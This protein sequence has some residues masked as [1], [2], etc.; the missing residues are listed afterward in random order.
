MHD[1]PLTAQSWFLY[2]WGMWGKT[3]INCFVLIT[4]YYMCKSDITLHKFL[5]LFL[6]IE[7]YA[8]VIYLI[9]VLTGYIDFQW[10][11]LIIT[12]WPIHNVDSG[13]VSG[14]LL[15]FLFIP[16]INVLV[17]NLTQ[18]YHQLL[19]LLSVTV[20]TLLAKISDLGGGKYYSFS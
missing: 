4:G 19:I 1:T 12:M 14:F 3:G 2:F 17:R 6:E 13:F 15:Y 11:D 10:G 20:Y 8:L 18:K 5:K 9:F 7:F 16:F